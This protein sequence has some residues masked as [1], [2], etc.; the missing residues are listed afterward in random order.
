MVVLYL[1]SYNPNVLDLGNTFIKCLFDGCRSLEHWLRILID[2]GLGHISDYSE[3]V[4]F[5]S[6]QHLPEIE[7]AKF[8]SVIELV[9][10]LE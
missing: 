3:F 8:D 10:T 7:S 4:R 9:L 5:N 2:E 1:S 6:L